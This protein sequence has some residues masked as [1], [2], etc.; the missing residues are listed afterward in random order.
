MVKRIARL[1]IGL[2]LAGLIAIAVLRPHGLWGDGGGRHENLTEL[3]TTGEAPDGKYSLIGPIFSAP[4]WLAGQL[5]NAREAWVAHYNGV[6]FALGLLAFYWMLRDRMPREVLRTF[7]LLLVFASMFAKHV[8]LYY[9]E[10]FTAVLV[11]VGTLA[12]VT[13]RRGGWAAIVIGVANTPASLVGMGFLALRRVWDTRRAWCLLAIFAA[14]A[15][16][17]AEA[18]I[19]RGNPFLTGYESGNQGHRSVMPYSGLPGFSYPLFF[20][21]L[22]LLLSFG[23]GLVFFAPGFFLPV[24]ERLKELRADADLGALHGMWMAFTVGLLLL[25]AN[26]WAWTGAHFW[27][28][29]YLLFASL[30]ACLVLAVRIH[31]PYDTLLPN[32]LTLAAV[33]LSV[34]VGVN[35]VVFGDSAATPTGCLV[36]GTMYEPPLCYY[37]PEFSALWYPFVEPPVLDTAQVVSLVFGLTAGAYVL[38]RPALVV[39]RQLYDRLVPSPRRIH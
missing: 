7:L 24:R 37:T 19:R 28:P 26:Y 11:A 32:V 21:L 6:V 27:G 30:P 33:A 29:R 4:L 14:A 8:T 10:V 39:F 23:K 1:E 35:G 25:Y 12:V 38:A 22:S 9:G 5:L 18:W 2:I 13:E 3:L 17:L 34:W 36:G 16:V 20:G 31:R 15:L